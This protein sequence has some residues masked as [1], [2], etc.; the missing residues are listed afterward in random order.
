MTNCSITEQ[1]R[2]AK[3]GSSLFTNTQLQSSV[4][5]A[6]A[7]LRILELFSI[8]IEALSIYGQASPAKDVIGCLCRKMDGRST[9][10]R[11]IGGDGTKSLFPRRRRT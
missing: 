3:T 10:P 11:N 5:L 2:N 8:E 7:R 9:T 4:E 1:Q 6:G